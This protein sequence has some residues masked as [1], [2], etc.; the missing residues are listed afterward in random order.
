ML[1]RVLAALLPLTLL[2]G[3]CGD[4][5]VPEPVPLASLTPTTTVHPEFD[6][7]RLPSTSVLGF[8]PSTATTLTVTDF[9]QVRVQLGMPDLTSEDLMADRTEFWTRAETEAVLLTEGMLRPVSSELMLDHGFT[10]DDVDWEAHFTGPEGNGYVLAFRPDLDMGLVSG[11]VADG[12][13]PLAGGTV[14]ASD[15]LVVSG[16]A[17]EGEQVWANEPALDGLLGYAAASTYARRGCIPVHDALGPDADDEDLQRVQQAHPLS[18]LDD[19]GAFAVDFGDHLATVRLGENREDLFGRLDVG[20]DWPR[21][22]FAQEFRQPV[23]DPTTGR[24][25]YGIP[26]PPR[27]AALTLLEE[28]PFGICNDATPIPEPTGL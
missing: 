19:L 10:Q 12:V 16:V 1:P 5:P 15:H 27:A 13:G 20:R 25:G 18:L 26:R 14:L 9:D 21:A 4:D 3:A 11:A 8:V 24:I 2:V 7:D 22:E 28:L 23:G 6:P 17:D